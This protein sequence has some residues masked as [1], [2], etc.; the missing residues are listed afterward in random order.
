MYTRIFVPHML[1]TVM[2]KDVDMCNG[3]TNKMCNGP[4]Y[5][6]FVKPGLGHV[7]VF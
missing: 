7:S 4:T 6:M 3:P 2:Q 1:K 5:N